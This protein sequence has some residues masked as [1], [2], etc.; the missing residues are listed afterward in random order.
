V[1]IVGHSTNAR[2]E[3]QTAIQT[4]RTVL[5][6]ED[7]DT[8][9]WEADQLRPFNKYMMDEES[10]DQVTVVIPTDRQFPI[11][12]EAFSKQVK[13]IIILCNGGFYQ[14][15]PLVESYSVAWEGHGK[16]R[17][18]ILE[19]ITTPYVFFSVD[20]AIPMGGMLKSLMESIEQYSFDAIIPRQI[21]WPSASAVTRRELQ[22]WTPNRSEPFQVPQS[23]HVGT[24]YRIKTLIDHPIPD[25]P[26]A[27]DAWWSIG[28]KVGCDPRAV[29]LHSHPRKMVDLFHR[30]LSIHREL[31]KMGRE[32]PFER[33]SDLISGGVGAGLNHGYREGIRTSASHVAQLLAWIGAR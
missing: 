10:T 27:E 24:L 11:G 15:S 22:R 25:V 3:L 17:Q 7:S 13:R 23:D 18:S 20:D 28:K 12:V 5:W 32:R 21:P 26:I 19:Q 6:Q 29:I 14:R 31:R 8:P 9:A 30:E 33:Y 4:K 2:F 16:T 1:K